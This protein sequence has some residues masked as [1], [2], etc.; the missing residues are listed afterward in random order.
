MSR[1]SP[2][3]LRVVPLTGDHAAALCTW[4]YD[5]PH[6]CYDMT[7]ADPEGLLDP[8]AG[9]HALVSGDELVGFRSF[10][11]DGRVPGWDYDDGALDTGGG[12]RP[13]L[14]GHGLGRHAIGVGLAFGRERFAPAAFRVTVASFNNRALRVVE[15]LGF[16]PVGRFDA[17]H[18][19]S[20]FEVLVRPET[21][22][23]D[24]AS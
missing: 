19:G 15:S 6:D 2:T 9:F 21:G 12:L 7:G 13:D 14:V 3:S 17:T 5:P 23:R 18:D 11:H 10:G 20:Q 22:G 1:P 16:S 24:G 4:R 8:A